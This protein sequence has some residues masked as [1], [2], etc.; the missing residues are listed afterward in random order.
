MLPLERDENP[1][2]N[3]GETGIFV[4]MSMQPEAVL[5]ICSSYN[6]YRFT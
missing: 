5:W 1:Q 6:G 4:D 3:E 2:D